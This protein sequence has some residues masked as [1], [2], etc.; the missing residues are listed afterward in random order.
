M[1]CKGLCHQ[2]CGPIA[3]S[4]AEERRIV[5]IHGS[6]PTAD[7]LNLRCSKLVDHR[8]SIYADR[9]LICRLWG[10]TRQLKCQHGCQPAGSFMPERKAGKLIRRMGEIA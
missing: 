6:P 8:C 9:P 2:A 7:S 4:P 3:M 5:A 1:Q 10:T